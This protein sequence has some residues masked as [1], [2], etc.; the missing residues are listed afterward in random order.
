[1]EASNQQNGVR[2]PNGYIHLNKP[3][4]VRGHNETSRTLRFDDLNKI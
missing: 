1:M 4:S 2:E 3:V